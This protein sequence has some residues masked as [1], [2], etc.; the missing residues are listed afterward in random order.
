AVSSPTITG[1]PLSG[2]NAFIKIKRLF[3]ACPLY[4][5]TSKLNGIFAQHRSKP[6]SEQTDIVERVLRP[7]WL[8]VF[9]TTGYP[10]R[11]WWQ[12]E[13]PPVPTVPP[14]KNL[15]ARGPREMLQGIWRPKWTSRPGYV[16]PQPLEMLPNTAG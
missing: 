6:L 4:R 11:V 10:T 8:P 16:P 2:N 14:K 13:G 7:S 5:S 12:A 3:T 15:A 1:G 9:V